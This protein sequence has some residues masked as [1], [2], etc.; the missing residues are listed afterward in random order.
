MW[1]STAAGVLRNRMTG[2]ENCERESGPR[3][4]RAPAN[5][6]VLRRRP[7]G[8]LLQ[9]IHGFDDPA[10]GTCTAGGR[11][12]GRRAARRD[13]SAR[14]NQDAVEHRLQPH[15]AG[16]F[17][18]SRNAPPRDGGPHMG[19]FHLAL[20]NYIGQAGQ[21]V[22]IDRTKGR[23]AWNNPV[24]EYQVTSIRD[25]G[26]RGDVVYKELVTKITYTWYGTDQVSQTNPET[27]E[28][29]GHQS[30]SMSIRYQLELD[31][32]GKIVGGRHE[33]RRPFPLGST[34]CRPRHRRSTF[35]GNR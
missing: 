24:Y 33:P 15:E 6:Y 22:G 25:A 10:P 9:R 16:Q 12:G 32:Q 5:L 11:R 23:E 4:V 20:A 29:Q 7:L 26:R 18:V 27:G 28:R 31:S 14:G 19:T 8:R 30:R 35:A 3:A 34:V 21:P 2:V 17:P 1:R 13:L